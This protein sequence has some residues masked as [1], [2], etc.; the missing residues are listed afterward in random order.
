[1]KYPSIENLYASNGEQNKDIR[2]G[3]EYGFS[4]ESFRQIARWNVEEKL[5]GTNVRVLLTGGD[6]PDH[7][8][9]YAGRTDNGQL[10]PRLLEW[11]GLNLPVWKVFMAFAKPSQEHDHDVAPDVILYGE[12]IGPKIQKAGAGYGGEQRMVLLDVLV[13]AGEGRRGH[14]LRRSSVEE[15]AWKLGIEVV[16]L[17]SWDVD[18]ETAKTYVSEASMQQS[19]E[20]IEGIVCK[21]DPP[22]FDSRGSRVQFK[23]K[24][25]D[26]D[27]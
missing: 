1:V 6:G 5:D 23:Y 17:L 4:R 10:P 25:R 3:P 14:W 20:H 16:P 2:R 7:A 15:V 22:L 26:L 24:I 21:A 11:L 8:I 12:G 19:D 13:G 9:R 27:G 18:L